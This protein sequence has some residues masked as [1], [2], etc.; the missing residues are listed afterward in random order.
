[1]NSSQRTLRIGPRAIR[2]LELLGLVILLM[3][4]HRVA[5]AAP[6]TQAGE[7]RVVTKPIEPFVFTDGPQ[8]RGFSIDLWRAVAAE[9]GLAYEFIVVDTVTQTLDALEAGEADVAI[10][11]ITITE[12]RERTFDFSLPYYRSGL[13]ILTTTGSAPGF[14][15]TILRGITPS[16]LR[17][18]G[19]LLIIILVAGHIIWL[20]ERRRN[21]E[22]FPQDYLHGVWQGIWWASVTVTT[23]G[24]GDK[25]PVSV[26]GRIFGLLWM[27]AGLFIIAS[28]TAGVTATLTAERLNAA[29]TRPQDLPGRTVATVA[30]STSAAWLQAQG[31]AHRET[32][33]IQQSYDLLQSGEVQAV[34]Y[35]YPVLRYQAANGGDPDVVLA[36]ELFNAELYG[37]AMPQ[38]S[39]LRER[40]DRALL[41][42][43]ETGAYHDIHLR[44]FG[45]GGGL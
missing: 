1:M 16:L 29:I 26:L 15:T 32:D 44:W 40:I 13:G 36:G 38:D 8:P 34:V 4:W 20:I 22:Q 7:L 10:A 21:P 43:I 14:V 30:G 33:L 11:A 41:R 9:A 37:I 24:Y 5:T 27:F 17:L 3:G 23:V 45:E 18:L 19:L 12:E 31:I 2:W 6:P 42:V 25:T 28:F 35:D 39:P